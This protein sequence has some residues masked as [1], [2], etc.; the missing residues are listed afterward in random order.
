[1]VSGL[2]VRLFVEAPNEV[3]E[4]VAHGD[5][6]NPMRM[7]GCLRA[8]IHSSYLLYHF[9]EPVGFLQLLDLVGEVELLNDLPGAGGKS[10]HELEEVRR[11]FVGIAK[12]LLE[13]EVARIV[14]GQNE[15]PIDQLLNRLSVILGNGFILPRL[16]VFFNLRLRL[17][18][19]VHGDDVVFRLL[20]HTIEATQHGER[21]HHATILRRPVG[22]A[23]KIGDVPDDI[24]VCFECV[25]VLHEMVISF[26]NFSGGGESLSGA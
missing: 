13:G 8:Q 24:A 3:L 11:E 18:L 14:E 15:L 2:L 21:N 10:G 22:P 20:Q 26:V 17:E 16:L 23:Q 25:E 19:L 6:R 9:E 7:F 12:E 4:H 5:V 1:V